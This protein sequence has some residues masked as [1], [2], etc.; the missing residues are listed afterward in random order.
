[1]ASTYEQFIRGVREIGT[2]HAVEALLEWDQETGMPPKAAEHRAAQLGWMARQAHERLTSDE[3]RDLLARCEQEGAGDDPVRMTNLREMR[4]RIDRAVKVPA[5]LVEQIATA[6]SRAKVAWIKARKENQYPLFAPHFERLLDLKRRVADC[7]GWKAEPYDALI[8]DYEPGATA[9]EIQPVFDALQKALVPLVKEIQA[10]S[11]KPKDEILARHCPAARQA[12]FSRMIVEAIGFDFEAGRIDTTVHPFCSG[13]SPVDVRLTT[14]YEENY[15][16]ASLFGSIHEAGH[17]LYEQ[18][19]PDEHA[20]TPAGAAISLGIHE[21][22]SRL[23][24]N[25]IGRG[26]PFWEHFFTALR[27]TFPTLADVSLDDWH[28][29]INRVTPSLIRVEADE[30]TYGLH[31]ILRFNLERQ[32]VAGKLAV[33]D[34]PAAWNDGMKALLGITPPSDSDGCLQD[35][36]WSSGIIGYFP[37]YSLGNLYAA[38]FYEKLRTDLGDL[39]GQVRRGE[40]APLLGWLRREIHQHGQRYRANE[41]VERVTGKPLAVDAFVAYLRSKYGALYG[42]S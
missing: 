33:K 25:F 38:Q 4:R 8:D 15:L 16:P 7:Y 40:F 11:R 1:M 32:L 6:C 30:V 22:Q 42:L 3:L 5:E 29:A 10:A 34:V 18:G 13:F 28:F 20:Y 35:I 14:R 23:W 37:T 41:L 9:G 24:E 39:D 27:E 26:R 17:G 36:H 21:S 12:A 19:L 31:I 2:I